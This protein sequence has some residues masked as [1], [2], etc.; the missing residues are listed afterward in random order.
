MVRHAR[1][2]EDGPLK[3]LTEHFMIDHNATSDLAPIIVDIRNG[4]YLE[5]GISFGFRSISPAPL[6][7]RFVRVCIVL[8]HL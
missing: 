7:V 1:G 6:R 5:Q 8:E 3:S 4:Q 2:L